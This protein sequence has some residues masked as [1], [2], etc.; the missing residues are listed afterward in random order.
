M[1]VKY[2]VYLKFSYLEYFWNNFI[3]LDE[4][5]FKICVKNFIVYVLNFI[6]IFLEFIRKM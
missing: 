5:Y 6:D 2:G 1:M 3:D 4:I